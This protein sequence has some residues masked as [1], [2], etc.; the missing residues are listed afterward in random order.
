[1]PSPSLLVPSCNCHCS[2]SYKLCHCSRKFLSYL[3]HG[4][5]LHSTKAPSLAGYPSA[6]TIAQP[7]G[8]KEQSGLAV[9]LRDGWTWGKERDIIKKTSPYLV[10]WSE[11]SEDVKERDRQTV[12]KIT[13][14]LAKVGLEIQRQFCRQ[15]SSG[16]IYTSRGMK[17][18]CQS[19][20]SL[21]REKLTASL[22]EV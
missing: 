5:L 8:E 18:L 6:L 13:E 14:F 15:P 3:L 2:T 7:V 1:V 17:R 12:H 22:N 11:L 4:L 9:G 16:E 21:I 19:S 10:G 20:T